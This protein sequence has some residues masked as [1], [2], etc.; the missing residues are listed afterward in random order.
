MRTISVALAFL[1]AAVGPAAA[2]VDE[3]RVGH[4][5][6]GASV[7][8]GKFFSCSATWSNFSG[9]DNAFT[10]TT[11]SARSPIASASLAY[12]NYR[13]DN[14]PEKHS[15]EWLKGKSVTM[16]VGGSFRARGK[17]QDALLHSFSFEMPLA[18]IDALEAGGTV[19]VQLPNGKRYTHKLSNS[20][21][22]IGNFKSC[23]SRYEGQ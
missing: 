4:W 21:E 15:F 13:D 7:D 18:V 23:R 17:I 16:S 9:E 5:F 1:L 8:N 3:W 22:A 6:G 20:R 10:V 14:T 19:V 11:Y 12:V 2:D